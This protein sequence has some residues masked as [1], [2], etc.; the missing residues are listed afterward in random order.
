MP[1]H[2]PSFVSTSLWQIP[3]ARTLMRTC[4]T[5]GLGISRSTIWK[6][7]PALG[8]WATFMGA[9][10]TLVVAINPPLN[11]QKL[12]K[13]TFCCWRSNRKLLAAPLSPYL[14][15]DLQLDRGAERKAC[16]P[17]H[18]AARALVF[19]EDVLQQFRSGVSDFRLIA[20]IPRSGHRHAEPH[21]PRHFVERPQ[22][23]PRDSQDVE[24]RK[25]SRLAPRFHIELRADAPNEFRLA[26]FRGKH[27]AQKKQIARLHRFCIS[28]EWLRRRREFDAKFFQP[29]LGAGR[30]RAFAGSHLLLRMCIHVSLSNWQM[31]PGYCQGTLM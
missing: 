20:D 19:S 13:S 31:L 2:A 27:P 22:I 18:Q 4:P 17:V 16:D 11:F 24:R 7:A 29:L 14:E 23:L 3:Q 8:T 15:N 10:A 21:D 1:G 9:T 26:A 5:P 6:S 25:V 28:A 30:P 12:S